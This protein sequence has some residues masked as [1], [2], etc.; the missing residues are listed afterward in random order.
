MRASAGIRGPVAAVTKE[1][2]DEINE[3]PGLEDDA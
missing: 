1:E 2:W 3:I